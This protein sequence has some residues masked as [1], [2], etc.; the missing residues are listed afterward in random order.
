M[1]K[2]KK[3]SLPPKFAVGDAVHVRPGVTDPDFSDMPLGG[4]TGT[5]KE[6]DV[7]GSSA[8]LVAWNSHTLQ[9][10]HPLF[11][12]RCEKGGFGFEEMW[13]GEEDLEPDTG[14]PVPME[15]PT[16]IITKPLSPNDQDDR[17]RAI[18]GLT[19]NDPVP[20][21]SEDRLLKYH[22]YLSKN[23]SFPFQAE[24]AQES[25]FLQGFTH[26]VTIQ[27]LLSP[28]DF[29]DDDYGL[30]YEGREDGRIVQL[31]LSEI[32]VDKRSPNHRLLE[33]YAYWFWNWR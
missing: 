3:P 28:Q 21:V 27:V 16:N 30:F 5:I 20:D 14:L 24:F 29:S 4:W 17:L 18:F 6:V 1:P 13:L 15:Q 7:G 11:R 25:G 23:L 10:A 8:Y 2:T 12:N 9:N 32:E 22:Q 31:P 26:Q 19:S 33:D